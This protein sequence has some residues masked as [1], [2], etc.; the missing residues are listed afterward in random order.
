MSS[1]WGGEPVKPIS[2]KRQKQ[3]I[4]MWLYLSVGVV[5]FLYLQG[6]LR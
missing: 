4:R 2:E 1:A 3:F 5:F 6:A